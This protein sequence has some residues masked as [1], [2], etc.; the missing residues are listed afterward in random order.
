MEKQKVPK[1]VIDRGQT[2][3]LKKPDMP[4]LAER[5]YNIVLKEYGS[6]P[7]E[8]CNLE[9]GSGGIFLIAD[10]SRSI[11]EAISLIEQAVY[12]EL[13]SEE[14]IE[15]ELQLY[16]EK[17]IIRILQYILYNEVENVFNNYW[18]EEMFLEVRSLLL[19]IYKI[20]KGGKSRY[21][22]PVVNKMV[23]ETSIERLEYIAKVMFDINRFP[24][25]NDKLLQFYL[26][27][28]LTYKE[29]VKKI[30]KRTI[31]NN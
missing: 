20:K 14:E 17:K 15:K 1:A 2:F 9:T 30:V 19:E 27:Q 18:T 29:P 28:I 12:S 7:L 4:V 8:F 3:Y 22:S 10:K 24:Y 26:L 11:R 5:L 25:W 6:M 21:I 31:V 16:S 23:S 13:W